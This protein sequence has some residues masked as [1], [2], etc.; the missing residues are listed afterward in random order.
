M[1]TVLF[2]LRAVV[3]VLRFVS[4]DDVLGVQVAFVLFITSGGWAKLDSVVLYYADLWYDRMASCKTRKNN[5][6]L[7]FFQEN[8]CSS[9][10]WAVPH[11]ER[12]SWWK[13]NSNPFLQEAGNPKTSTRETLPPARWRGQPGLGSD[14]CHNRPIGLLGSS[15]YLC[16]VHPSAIKVER[17]RC[18]F[19]LILIPLDVSSCQLALNHDSLFSFKQFWCHSKAPKSG[20]KGCC[21][22]LHP[23]LA[24]LKREVTSG[25]SH[26]AHSHTVTLSDQYWVGS[27]TRDPHACS[28]SWAK[29]PRNIRHSCCSAEL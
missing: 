6:K 17:G 10:Q 19:L 3:L 13:K 23:S 15:R 16:T 2:V 14:V 8:C 29:H 9:L 21:W 4:C 24:S 1:I 5:H 26:S 22:E 25:L 11:T 7:G 20:G 18:H 27:A 12:K 28:V